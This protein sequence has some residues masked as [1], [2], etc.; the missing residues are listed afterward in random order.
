[1]KCPFIAAC[2][3]A[4]S[5]PAWAQTVIYPPPITGQAVMTATGTSAAISAANVT[6]VTNSSGFPTGNLPRGYLRVKVLDTQ[7]GAVTICWFGGTCVANTGEVIAVGESGSKGIPWNIGTLP[8]SVVS[9]AGSV[10]FE[11]EW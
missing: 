11:L 7:G 8:P 10:I 5:V 1:M 4:A 3:I 9:N 6:L 2:L